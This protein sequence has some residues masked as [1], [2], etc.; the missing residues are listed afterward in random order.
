MEEISSLVD[1]ADYK[2]ALAFH[3]TKTSMRKGLN[4]SNGQ[5]FLELFL[6]KMK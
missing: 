3:F 1:L 5:D 4:P 2:R 6:E